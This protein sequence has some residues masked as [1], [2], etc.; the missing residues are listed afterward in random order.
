M[1]ENNA[2]K[3]TGRK[4]PVIDVKDV[5]K[6]FGDVSPVRG[7]GFQVQKGEFVT[8]LGPSGSGKTTLLG[9]LAG[10]EQPSKGSV[11]LHDQ[12]LTDLGEDELALL[13]RRMV[14]FVFQAFHLIPT[15]NALENVAFPLYPV[16]M[17]GHERQ[18]RAKD[19]LDKM[20][21]GARANHLPSKLSGG[22]R[23]R[24]AIARALINDPEI[25]FC[26]EPTGNLD[27]AT[28]KEIL[29]LLTDLNKNEGVTIFM[30]THDREIAK[31]SDRSL[32]MTDG[33]VSES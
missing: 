5:S 31:L 28:G 3:E 24:V 16:K 15:L 17:S 4:D 19:L 11:S 14:G 18:K 12:E 26:D 32:Y 22:E 33:E 8:L 13:R 21:L 2:V 7:V 1:N 23:Q 20:G 9:L 30:V 29:N 6:H 25:L 27:S 10:F